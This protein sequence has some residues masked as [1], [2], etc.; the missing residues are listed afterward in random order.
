MFYDVTAVIGMTFHTK[1]LCLICEIFNET[2]FGL[3]HLLYME[4]SPSSKNIMGHSLHQS[5]S[6]ETFEI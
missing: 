3:G 2:A 1:R 5:F 4:M 6:Y